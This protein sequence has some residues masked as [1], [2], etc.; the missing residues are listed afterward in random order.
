FNFKSVYKNVS[1]IYSVL[2]L[3]DIFRNLFFLKLSGRAVY[4]GINLV[5]KHY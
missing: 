2:V 3:C 1:E 5:C 4:F